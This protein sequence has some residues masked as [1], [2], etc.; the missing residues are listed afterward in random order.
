MQQQT[1]AKAIISLQTLNIQQSP[2]PN[3]TAI[4]EAEVVTEEEDP[5]L[6]TD[7]ITKEEEGPDPVQGRDQI[8]IE[9]EIERATQDHITYLV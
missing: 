2:L 5:V 4:I 1:K 3:D 7:D 6:E 9:E 8:V